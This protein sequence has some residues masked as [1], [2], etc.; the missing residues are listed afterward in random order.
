MFYSSLTVLI[1]ELYFNRNIRVSEFKRYVESKEYEERV[2]KIQQEVLRKI[3]YVEENE[4]NNVIR[5]LE[6]LKSK[7]LKQQA[8]YENSQTS[9]FGFHDCIIAP[10]LQTI[11]T[12]HLEKYVN[13]DNN[14]LSPLYSF[15]TLEARKSAIENYPEDFNKFNPIFAT[16]EVDKNRKDEVIVIK[17]LKAAEIPLSMPYEFITIRSTTNLTL[18]EFYHSIIRKSYNIQPIDV[19]SLFSLGM[20]TIWRHSKKLPKYVYYYNKEEKTVKEIEIKSKEDLDTLIRGLYWRPSA[21]DYYPAYITGLLRFSKTMIDTYE[22]ENN[23]ENKFFEWLLKIDPE[24]ITNFIVKLEYPND[25]T[26]LKLSQRTK[27]IL[28]GNLSKDAYELIYKPYFSH[29][30]LNMIKENVDKLLNQI[31]IDNLSIGDLQQT[32]S[33]KVFETAFEN[34]KI[35]FKNLSKDNIIIEEWL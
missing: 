6:D 32:I 26:L 35:K 15:V 25:S 21:N 20:Y 17:K 18:P 10:S 9:F 5:E 31:D 24:F 14:N 7:I 23:A 28:I 30:L 12:M 16:L 34:K 2:K 13:N 8:N 29:Q 22:R 11:I 4:I 1:N 19:S 33:I 3:Y 27:N